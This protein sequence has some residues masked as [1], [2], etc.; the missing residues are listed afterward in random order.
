MSTGNN[1]NNDNGGAAQQQYAEAERTDFYSLL[2]LAKSASASDIKK[3]FRV[4][5]L[6]YHPDR[7]HQQEGFDPIASEERVSSRM[8][9]DIGI[10]PPRQEMIWSSF[11]CH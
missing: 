3:A 9:V 4:L 7:A 8:C 10:Q 1:N 5:A 2:G 6:K 11:N